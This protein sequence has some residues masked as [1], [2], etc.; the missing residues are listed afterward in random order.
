MCVCVCV[1]PYNPSL[2]AVCFGGGVGACVLSTV[3]VQEVHIPIVSTQRL[4][5]PCPAAAPG[6]ALERV[7]DT[8]DTSAL[9]QSVLYAMGR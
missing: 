9:A 1:N 5:L 2:M 8:L 6:S 7:G 3:L 4:I